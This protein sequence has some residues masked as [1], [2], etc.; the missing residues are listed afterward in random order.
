MVRTDCIKDGSFID[1]PY[2][3][4][5]DFVYSDHFADPLERYR[6]VTSQTTKS[7]PESMGRYHTNWHDVS[8]AAAGS[9][10]VAG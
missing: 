8:P 5:N 2:N 9:E 3:T 4:G 7:N 1:P 6:E 10:S